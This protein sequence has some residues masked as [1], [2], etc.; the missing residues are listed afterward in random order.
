MFMLYYLMTNIMKRITLFL[1]IIFSILPILNLSADTHEFRVVKNVK[2]ASPKGF[3]L[4][5]DIYIPNTGKS[6]YPVLVIYHG[7]GWLINNNSI[8]NDMSKYIAEHSE[9]IICNVNYRLLGDNNNTTTMNEI[10]EDAFGALLWI[11]ENI[12]Q[13][14]GDSSRIA[15][16]GDSAGGHL[17]EMVV[18]CGNN[19]SS[20]GFSGSSLGFNPTYLPK[21]KTAE[22]IRR[23][24]G[25]TVQ[26]AILSYAAYDIYSSCLGDF[27][28][29]SNFFWSM[30]G[31]TA[32]GIF[33]DSINVNKNPEYYK[34][35]SPIYNIPSSNE[36]K[37]PPQL[38]TA[39]SKDNLITPA[40]VQHYVQLLKD[41]GHPAEYWEYEGRPHAFLDSGSNQYL[42]ISFEKD[43]P[44]AIDRIVEFLNK[45]L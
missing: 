16:T 33:G 13:Y 4:T 8:M 32:R 5:M 21:G 42:G 37:L 29:P 27:E 10:V 28:K 34:A 3:D 1:L 44:K 39:G 43:G 23:E 9:Y 18:I 30:T 40:I 12:K 31:K 11:K 36:R 22:D 7:G 38:C 17:A 14:G 35:V 19:L 15:V 41:A 25:L 24:N 6:S 45:Y 2:W 26:A 20:K